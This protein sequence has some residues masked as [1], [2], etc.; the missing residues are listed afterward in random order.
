MSSKRDYYEV[1]GVSRE[2]S[3]DEI[4][5]SYRQCAL[6]YHP[7]RNPG[8][9]AAEEKFKEATE[10]F[11]ILSDD[12]KRQM[13]DRYGHAGLGGSGGVDFSNVGIGDILSQFQDLFSDFF[14]G[15]SGFGGGRSSRGPERGQNVQVDVALT[16]E[17]VMTGVKR[18]VEVVGAAPCET[19]SG[20]GAAPGTSPQ[21]CNACGGSGQVA[22]QRGF[23]VFASTC[24]QCRGTGKTVASPCE[25]CK[26]HGHVEK[27][28]K[29]LVNIPGG[30]DSG[31]QLRLSGQGMP[32]RPG[33]PAGDLY[34]QIHVQDDP[35]FERDGSDLILHESVSFSTAALGG[36]I[37]VRL[38][39]KSTASVHLESGT[40][41]GSLIT[42]RGRGLPRLDR[43]G[44]RG[45]LHV[46]VN[47][48]VPKKLSRKAKKLLEE[49]EAECTGN[50]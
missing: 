23:I 30:V 50:A 10:A 34:V 36:K 28:R 45:D 15:F 49:F 25:A 22:S 48:V 3:S 26:G 42:L 24:G 8:D 17:E 2:A 32:G 19:C 44:G 14:G 6:K 9:K 13:Y 20:S 37:E 47:V 7:D 1:L 40:Q 38:P 4:R 16:L 11:S 18:E 46:V 33:A 35:R 43:S 12:Q 29:V 41:P 27:R 31:V 5:K 39:D 21:R